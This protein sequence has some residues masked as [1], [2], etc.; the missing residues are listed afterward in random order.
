M[1]TVANVFNHL[2]LPTQIPGKQDADIEIIN[3]DVLVRLIH[4]TVTLG[5]LACEKQASIWH[6]VRQSL[7]C[8]QSLHVLGRLEKQSLIAEFRLLKH[9]QPLILHVAEQN[10]ALIIRRDKR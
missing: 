4:A 9:D 7:R 10:A 1:A 5:K 8:C 6:A 2:V 3:S